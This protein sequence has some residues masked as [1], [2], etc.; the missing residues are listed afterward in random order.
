MNLNL[1]KDAKCMKIH[2][3]A[4]AGT[5]LQTSNTI[6]M[7]GYDSVLLIADLGAVT[8]NCV[9]QL[10]AQDGAAS[11]GSDAANITATTGPF[12]A[13]GGTVQTAAFTALTSSNKAILLDVQKPQ[14]RYITATLSRT[15]QNAVVNSIWA[16]LYNSTIKPIAAQDSSIIA[17]SEFDCGI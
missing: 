9:L 11:N 17:S 12:A 7:Q 15:T 6:D 13:A 4:V 10:T 14:K 8:D 3:G 5:S 2:N 16:I 1:L